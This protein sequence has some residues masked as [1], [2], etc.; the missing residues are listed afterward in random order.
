MN[1]QEKYF[2]YKNKYLQLKNIQLGQGQ[3]SKGSLNLFEG[4]RSFNFFKGGASTDFTGTSAGGSH[5]S[6]PNI[7]IGFD[8]IDDKTI[9]TDGGDQ[10]SIG[11]FGPDLG[12]TVLKFVQNN[13]NTL[14]YPDGAVHNNIGSTTL[15]T[16]DSL[17]LEFKHPIIT[18][19]DY[20]YNYRH[21]IQGTITNIL[22]KY[23]SLN[24]TLLIKQVLYHYIK[25][26][27]FNN[28]KT[29]IERTND[30]YEK[31]YSKFI[32]KILDDPRYNDKA[33]EIIIKELEIIS[34]HNF[35]APY[36]GD[37]MPNL[38]NMYRDDLGDIQQIAG[39][40]LANDLSDFQNHGF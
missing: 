40:I 15:Y 22:N 14:E 36:M 31:I 33:R 38:N 12:L 30:Y 21:L 8:I 1:Y 35:R 18:L 9:T 39:E 5:S 28:K 32:F 7:I 25:Y 6:V 34:T 13:P 11:T 27:L 3:R 24:K 19:L 26:R 16:I 29:E 2:K 17:H 10:V 20:L 4:Q 23:N 37:L